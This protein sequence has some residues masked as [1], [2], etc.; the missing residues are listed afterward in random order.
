MREKT[1]WF[2]RGRWFKAIC[3]ISILC[4]ITLYYSILFDQKGILSR[5]KII[6]ISILFLNLWFD[7]TLHLNIT[8]LLIHASFCKMYILGTLETKGVKDPSVVLWSS[9]SCFL[10]DDPVKSLYVGGDSSTCLFRSILSKHGA[11]TQSWRNVGPASVTLDQHQTNI[12]WTSRVCS[13]T[14][15][16]PLPGWPR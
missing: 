4:K 9:I 7:N 13:L 1:A 5:T 16:L 2:M 8:Y 12:G 10:V 15:G 14:H 11:L 3:N 6:V